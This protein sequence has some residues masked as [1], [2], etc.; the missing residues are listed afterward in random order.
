MKSDRDLL[1]RRSSY[2]NARGS[3]PQAIKHRSVSS[4]SSRFNLGSLDLNL[5]GMHQDDDRSS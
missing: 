1:A 3:F 4:S 5:F 2:W